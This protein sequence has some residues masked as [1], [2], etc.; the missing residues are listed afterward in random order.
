[1]SP[2]NT[3]IHELHKRA[4]RQFRVALYFGVAVASLV[5]AV[6]WLV[7]SDSQQTVRIQTTERVL[8]ACQSA[9]D[10]QQCRANRAFWTSLTTPQEACFILA[11]GGIPCGA[12]TGDVKKLRERLDTAGATL[13]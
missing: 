1:M 4:A 2:V 7:Y 11:Q 9:P 5:I 13:P 8:T 3:D 6:G 10:G 12:P